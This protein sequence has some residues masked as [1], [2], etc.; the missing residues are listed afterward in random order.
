MNQLLTPFLILG[1][2]LLLVIVSHFTSKKADTTTFFTADRKSPWYLVAFGMIGTTIS[3]VTFISVP[4]EVGNSAFSYLQFVF[5]N[6]LGFWFVALILLPLYYKLNLISIYSFLDK[7]L[8][9]KSYK[10]GSFFFLISKLIGASFRLYLVA[11]VLQIAFFD[12]IHI[13]FSLTVI[14]TI[15]LVWVYTRRGGV[16]TIVWTDSF[17]TV[18]LISAV[19]FAIVSVSNKIEWNPVQMLHEINK[20]DYSQIFF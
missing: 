5:G 10:T 6:L 16:K 19:L 13:P 15:A 3:G 17:Q 2:F 20:S 18:L 4:G 9:L 12:S 8:G 14:V 1:Y 11:T 7:R